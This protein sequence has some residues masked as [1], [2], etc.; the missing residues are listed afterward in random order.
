MSQGSFG[1]LSTQGSSGT[2][3]GASLIQLVALGAADVNLTA[4]PDVTFWRLRVQKCT[5]F[6]LEGITQNFNSSP[7]FGNEIQLTLNRTGDLIHWMYCLIDLPAIAAVEFRD[8]QIG[9]ACNQFPCADP[10]DPCQD[11]EE[12]A[13]CDP[14]VQG[15]DVVFGGV[16]ADDVSR[17]SSSELDLD[18]AHRIPLTPDPCT[19]LRRPYCHWVNEIGHAAI[20]RTTF[21]VGGQ[22]IDTLYNHFLHMWEEL[23]GQPGKRLEEMIGK[24]YTTAALVR[25]SRYPRR[26]YVPLPFYFTRFAGDALPLVSLQFHALQVSVLFTNLQKLIQVSDCNTRVVR[27]IDGTPVSNQDIQANLDTTYTYL[28][29]EERDRF[30]TGSFQ[31]LITQVQQYST[32]SR[33]GTITAQLNFNHPTVELIWAVQRKCQADR[34]NIFN[35]SGVHGRDPITRAQLRLNNLARFDRE[36]GYFRMVQPYQ[37]HTNIPKNFI[38]CYSFALLPESCQPSG[39]LNFS[40]ID[41]IELQ[42]SLQNEVSMQKEETA[43]YCFA[44]SW[45]ILRLKDGLGGLLYSS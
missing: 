43:L 20:S 31:Q 1:S 28:D 11:G 2:T 6:A 42:L 14:F 24:R 30:A 32:S 10:C 36:A 21:S 9:N 37:H 22:V 35:Y 44:R 7:Q 27:C 3:Q 4:N 33:N 26:L 40:R 12:F 16:N 5:N 15:G 13:P 38:Y 25:D 34:N 23:S 19:G 41:S 17:V 39:S 18:V 8:G 45:N 29:M